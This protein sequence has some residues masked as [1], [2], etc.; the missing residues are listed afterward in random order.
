MFIPDCHDHEAPKEKA[1]KTNFFKCIRKLRPIVL[2]EF[3]DII[4]Y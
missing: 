1:S 4:A 3:A 2:L